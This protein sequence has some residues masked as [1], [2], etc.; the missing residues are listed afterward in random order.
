MDLSLQRPPELTMVGE[1]CGGLKDDTGDF[2]ADLWK[3][4]YVL[5]EGLSQ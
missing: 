1:W 4:M 5:L 2:Q 3:S